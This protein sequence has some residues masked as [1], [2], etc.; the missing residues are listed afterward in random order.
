MFRELV[1]HHKTFHTEAG[2]VADAI[3]QRQPQRA[4][5]MMEGGSPFVEAGH[6]VTQCIRSLRETVEGGKA[7][8]AASPA[9]TRPATRLGTQTA[10]RAPAPAKG[11]T[12]TRAAPAQPHRAANPPAA[13]GNDDWE[14]F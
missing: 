14:T 11:P 12:A 7:Q 1:S 3:N 8:A 13:I 6:H 9:P 10:A 5:Q 4:E 2:K